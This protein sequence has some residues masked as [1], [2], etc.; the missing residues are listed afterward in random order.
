MK[1]FAYLEVYK[2]PSKKKTT[3]LTSEAKVDPNKTL[4]KELC[5]PSG[6]VFSTPEVLT[7][8]H[9]YSTRLQDMQL[10]RAKKDIVKSVR[11]AQYSNPRHNI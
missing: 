2:H 7:S 8:Y 1:H 11:H 6:W 10:S 3:E 9:K 5:L 4:V